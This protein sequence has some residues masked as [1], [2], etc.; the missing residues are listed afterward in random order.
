M[1]HKMMSLLIVATLLISILFT[2]KSGHENIRVG[3]FGSYNTEVVGEMLFLPEVAERYSI[4][5]KFAW[6]NPTIRR[7]W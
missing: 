3:E 1:K 6:M 4:L 5:R 7:S 2:L